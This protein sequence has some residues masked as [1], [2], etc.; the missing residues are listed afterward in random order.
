MYKKLLIVF[1]CFLCIGCGKKESVNQFK[2]EYEK[3]NDEYFKLNLSEDDE[4]VYSTTSEVNKIIKS[5]T[6]VIFF[7]SPK[8]NLSRVVVDILLDVVNNTD[9]DHIYYLDNLDGITGIDNIE[10]KKI[11]LVLFVLDGKIVSYH[12]GTVNDK[13]ELSDDEIVELYNLYSD[14]VHQVL[15][16]ACDENC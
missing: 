8:D 1:L 2:K 14:G 6:G 12:V 5:G 3:Y 7:G 9:L 16:D 4:V 15:Q 13:V 10:G 11:P